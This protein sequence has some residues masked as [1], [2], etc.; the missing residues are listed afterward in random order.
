MEEFQYVFINCDVLLMLIK[1]LN[2]AKAVE[3]LPKL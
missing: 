2:A 3:L 1:A